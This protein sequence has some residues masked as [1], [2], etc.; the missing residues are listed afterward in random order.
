MIPERREAFN[1]GFKQEYYENLQ[2]YVTETLGEP[3][4]FRISETPVF[5]SKEI[6]EKVLEASAS[7]LDQIWQLDMD[8]VRQRF[9]PKHLQSPSPLGKPHFLAID[10]GLCDD[11]DGNISPQ[12]IELQAFPS[13][14]YYQPFLGKAFLHNYPNLDPTGLHYFFGNLDETS[15]LKTVNKVILGDENPENVI[16]MELFPEKQKTRIDFWA[17]KQAS[18]IEVVCITKVIKEGKKLFYEKDG[19]RIPIHRIYNRVIFDDMQRLENVQTN[20]NLFD[21][22]DVDWITHPDWFFMISKCIMPML[23]H[24]FI[25]QSYYLNDFPPDLQ[26]S[27][28]VLKPLFSFAGHGIDL[29]PTLESISK[30]TDKTNF[31]LQRKVNYA[32]IIKTN[33]DK[34]SKVELRILFVLDSESNKL[35]P[36]INLTRMGK[37]GLINVSHQNADTWIG[38]SISFFED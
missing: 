14:M 13:L 21:E 34:N 11:A 19:K 4:A 1:K 24:E 10:F 20:F 28:F 25:P 15:Y 35:K 31:L 8:A 6:K 16:L 36:V 18:G 26:L 3:C 37:G 2:N 17:T 38:S 30:I 22:V 5:I 12:L 32:P 9:M 33:T 23:R 27:D 29:N 7:I